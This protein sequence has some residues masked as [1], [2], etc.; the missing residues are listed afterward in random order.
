MKKIEPTSYCINVL[1]E[2]KCP[3]CDNRQIL[4]YQASAYRAVEDDKKIVTCFKCKEKYE[5]SYD[6]NLVINNIKKT[7]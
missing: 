3:S 5:I 4:R 7:L 6:L 1:L 2:W